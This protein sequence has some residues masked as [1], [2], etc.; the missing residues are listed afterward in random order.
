[1]RKPT[2][3]TIIFSVIACCLIPRNASAQTI[4]ELSDQLVEAVGTEWSALRDQAL[5]LPSA[6]YDA[7]L[8]VLDADPSF[9][10]QAVAK[11]LRRR[12]ANPAAAATLEGID[13]ALKNGQGVLIDAAGKPNYAMAAEDQV[14]ENP[15][16]L[17]FT[18]EVAWKNPTESELMRW[19]VRLHLLTE[20]DWLLWVQLVA[21]D[22]PYFP[23][24]YGWELAE[25][26]TLSN[27]PIALECL[28]IAFIACRS[29]NA[30]PGRVSEA[31]SVA[32]YLSTSGSPEALDMLQRM[33]TLEEQGSANQFV[34]DAL[35]ES[36]QSLE[37]DLG[38]AA[39]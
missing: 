31:G 23:L 6:E 28:E 5:A 14:Q 3:I 9:D 10:H 13:Q 16:V 33:R 34:L 38:L 35:N 26:V 25:Q 12:E 2:R 11:L 17:V 39:P 4:A 27:S 32:L 7:L 1:M 19:A 37:S 20:Q 18:P 29:L 24:W 8:A 15:E 22:D 30:D 21:E 36:I